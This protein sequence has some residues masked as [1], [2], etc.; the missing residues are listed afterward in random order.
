MI[1]TNSLN[2]W[3]IFV[4]II[5]A[6][7]FA[8]KW[9]KI[10]L[11]ISFFNCLSHGWMVVAFSDFAHSFWE[12]F[13]LFELFQKVFAWHK[14]GFFLWYC[15]DVFSDDVFFWW[16]SF[17][18]WLGFAWFVLFWVACVLDWFGVGFVIFSLLPWVD[19][20]VEFLSEVLKGFMFEEVKLILHGVLLILVGIF[21]F[22]NEFL[23]DVDLFLVFCD[24]FE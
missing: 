21:H 12:K 16:F 1:K 2:L 5:F 11:I 3:I 6:Y 9:G 18:D 8:N 13:G 24:N 7:N 20:E 15:Q 19:G 4:F 17:W 10:H 14:F 23:P 22:L